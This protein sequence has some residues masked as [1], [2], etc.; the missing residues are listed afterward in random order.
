MKEK[1]TLL[2]FSIEKE[3]KEAL[4][5]IAKNSKGKKSVSCLMREIITD[6]LEKENAK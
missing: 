4:K 6:F 3:Q 2:C 1:L 5:E